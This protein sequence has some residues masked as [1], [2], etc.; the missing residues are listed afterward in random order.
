ML[1]SQEQ[2]QKQHIF[3]NTCCLA[4]ILFSLPDFRHTGL[5][6]KSIKQHIRWSDAIYSDI[7]LNVV[8]H[9]CYRRYNSSQQMLGSTIWHFSAKR[10][11][12]RS[13]RKHTF[14]FILKTNCLGAPVNRLEI[15]HIVWE[16]FHYRPAHSENCYLFLP[17]II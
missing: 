2:P 7:L 8:E 17:W 12:R 6:S 5:I 1:R 10:T 14:P 9:L 3:L 16:H 11:L 15:C 13:C 4:Y